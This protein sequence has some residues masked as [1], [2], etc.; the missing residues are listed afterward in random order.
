MAKIDDPSLE[1]AAACV[2][3]PMQNFA[4]AFEEPS[5]NFWEIRGHDIAKV[6]LQGA[7]LRKL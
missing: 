5:G 7:R 1:K 4:N 3:Y 6:C 2:A